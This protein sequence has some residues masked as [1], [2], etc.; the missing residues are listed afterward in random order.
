[1]PSSG[2]PGLHCNGRLSSDGSPIKFCLAAIL[3][4]QSHVS[5]DHS[6]EHMLSGHL[7]S[8]DHLTTVCVVQVLADN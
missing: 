2:L 3:T 7:P 8:E 1:M 4:G 5:G 6:A